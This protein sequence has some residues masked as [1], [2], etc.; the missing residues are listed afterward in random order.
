[1]VL[2]RA[3]FPH[4]A[5]LG[6]SRLCRN[7]PIAV[8][9]IVREASSGSTSTNEPSSTPFLIN[10][11]KYLKREGFRHLHQCFRRGFVPGGFD[12]VIDDLQPCIQESKEKCLFALEVMVECAFADPRPPLYILLATLLTLK[13]RVENNLVAEARIFARVFSL[14]CCIDFI[15][16]YNRLVGMFLPPPYW[17]VKSGGNRKQKAATFVTAFLLI[18]LITRAYTP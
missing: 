4:F 8:E 13:P 9:T 7:N 2:S 1:M 17:T 6:S 5:P 11:V 14:R 10:E 3:T 16:K 12:G 15:N 18:R